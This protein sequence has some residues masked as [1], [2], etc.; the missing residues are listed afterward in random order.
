MI[1]LSITLAKYGRSFR[2]TKAGPWM[3]PFII[4][5]LIIWGLSKLDSPLTDERYTYRT[6]F[7]IVGFVYSL[8]WLCGIEAEVCLR[9]VLCFAFFA[10]MHYLKKYWP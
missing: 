3:I 6:Y 7:G 1:W 4:T 9:G 2:N 5:F 10:L 8:S